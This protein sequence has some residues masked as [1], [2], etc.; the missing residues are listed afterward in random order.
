MIIFRTTKTLTTLGEELTIVSLTPSARRQRLQ[1]ISKV[2]RLRKVPS[3][4]KSFFDTDDVRNSELNVLKSA[5]GA[6]G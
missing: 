3:H 4:T 5:I 6:K 1:K 2:F